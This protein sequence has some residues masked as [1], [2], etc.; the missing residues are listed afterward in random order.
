LPRALCSTIAHPQLVQPVPPSL[1]YDADGRGSIALPELQLAPRVDP[2]YALTHPD[3]TGRAVRCLCAGFCHDGGRRRRF[4]FS[5]KARRRRPGD[6]S[7]RQAVYSRDELGMLTQSF[8]RMTRQLDAR[9]ETE[10]HRS[11]LESARGYLESILANLSA[12]V[13]FDRTGAAHHQRGR[14]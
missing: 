13:L 12:G 3:C 14:L 5:P 11:E 10:R 6:F 2:I 7:P 4:R 1:A 8:S 9:R